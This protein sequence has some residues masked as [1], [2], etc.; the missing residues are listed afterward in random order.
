M[1][2]IDPLYK[3]IISSTKS[4]YDNDIN[5]IKQKYRNKDEND[6]TDFSDITDMS[7][8]DNNSDND[9]DNLLDND[10]AD[11][12]EAN[13]KDHFKDYV[14]R[15]KLFIQKKNSIYS[16]DEIFDVIEYVLATGSSWRSLNLPVF[17]GNYKWQSFY[18]HFQK[19]SKANVFK[20]T[21]LELLSRYFEDNKS[22]KLK[23]LSSDTSY[24]KNEYASDTDFGFYKKKKTSKL[25]L[26]TSSEGIAISIELMK[27][28]VSDQEMLNKNLENMF[29]DI[30]VTKT[31]N[32]INNKHKRYFLADSGYDSNAIRNNIKKKNIEPIIWKNKRNIKDPDLIKKNK[33]K[34]NKL[35]IYKRRIKIEHCFSWLYKNRRVNRR[36]DK[37][38]KTYLS[39][40]FMALTKILVKRL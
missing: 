29:I 32:K 33:I 38:K 19:F 8:Y 5:F 12:I 20:N 39:F 37:L 21:Y 35:K 13:Y 16:L 17:K 34:G 7:S 4:S 24:I 25:S 26:I 30:T 31:N 27:G 9:N 1:N 3:N 23:F 11:F 28:S 15:H 2:F 6:N 14:I 18:Y 40:L 22:G 10:L 36:Y